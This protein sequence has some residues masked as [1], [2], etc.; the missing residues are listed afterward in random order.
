MTELLQVLRV[1]PGAAVV[2]SLTLLIVFLLAFVVAV[3][4]TAVSA[5]RPSPLDEELERF[6][7]ETLATQR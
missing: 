1:L 5:R 3:G 6:L 2:G 4:L 7:R